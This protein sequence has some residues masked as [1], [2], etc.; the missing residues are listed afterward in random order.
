MTALRYDE[1]VGREAYLNPGL[2]FSGGTLAREL[3]MLRKLCDKYDCRSYLID[4][5]TKVNEEQN[6]IVVKKV[7]HIFGTVARKVIGVLGLTYKPGTSTLRRSVSLEII[8]EL[9]ERGA[10]IKAYDP[11]ATRDAIQLRANLE[12]CADPY[13]AAR[14]SDVLIVLTEWPEFRDLDFAH[15]RSI[16]KTPIL[17]DA[18]NMYDHEELAKLGFHCVGI[19]RGRIQERIDIATGR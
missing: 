1:R 16:R 18:K 15:V 9:I 14:E 10:S 3:K 17:I 11:K 4:S 6:K 8:N 5:V 12:L 13:A 7:E 2:G 19:G